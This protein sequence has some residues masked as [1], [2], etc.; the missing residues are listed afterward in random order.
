MD[1]RLLLGTICA[2]R[3]LIAAVSGEPESALI[4]VVKR[5]VSCHQRIWI[6]EPMP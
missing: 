1:D 4:M 3:T 6:S 5:S 2:F